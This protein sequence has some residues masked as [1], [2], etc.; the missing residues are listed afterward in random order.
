[1]VYLVLAA[2][3]PVLL[4]LIYIYRKDSRQPEPLGW[5]LR[6]FLYGLGS[7]C[8]SLMITS[9]LQLTGFSLFGNDNPQSI[10]EAFGHAFVWAA[11]PEESAKLLML[12]L[13]LRKNP[14]FDEY[15][16]GIVYATCVGL[17]FAALENVMYV[18]NGLADGSWVATSISRALFAV[19]GHFLF[20]VLMGYYYS[21]Y[22]Y[23]LR[24]TALTKVLVWLAPVLAHG[25]YDGILFSMPTSEIFAAVGMMLFLV[26]FVRLR[27][28]GTRHIEHLRELGEKQDTNWFSGFHFTRN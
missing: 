4:L 20:A 24:R 3:A 14:Y 17:G 13:L 21:L 6:A 26:F 1:M 11:I 25:I 15:L 7:V 28:L 16:D 19:P 18:Y 22:Y 8:V 9:S 23:G 12:W 2:L 27:K 10:G 5:L